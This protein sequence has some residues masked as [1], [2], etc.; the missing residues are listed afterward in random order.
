MPPKSSYTE[1]SVKRHWIQNT[2]KSGFRC[3]YCG[4]FRQVWNTTR[5][6]QHSDACSLLH[7]SQKS[8]A[9]IAVAANSSQQ[10]GL[11][12]PFIVVNGL[13]TFPKA[14]REYIVNRMARAVF[15]DNLPFNIFDPGHEIREAFLACHP[16]M[17]FPSSRS[18]SDSRLIEQYNATRNTVMKLF[19]QEEMIGFC[20]DE[21]NN[22]KRERIANICV[23]SRSHGA[24]Y[25][26]SINIKTASIDAPFLTKWL[27]TEMRAFIEELGG[28]SLK[29]IS[30]FSSDTY[31]TMLAVGRIL[32]TEPDFSHLIIVPCESYSLQLLIKD[33]IELPYWNDVFEQAGSIVRAFLRS[34]K[35][36]GILRDLMMKQYNEHRS[37]CLSIIT[38]W[39]TQYRLIKSLA[40]CKAVLREYFEFEMDPD[41]VPKSIIDCAKI[42]GDGMFWHSI[43]DCV[44][45]FSTIDEELKK[46]ESDIASICHTIGH[47]NSIWRTIR[48][49]R[50]RAPAVFHDKNGVDVFDTL[51]KQ[52]TDR[53][54]CDEHYLAWHLNP[55]VEDYCVPFKDILD[56]RKACH[57]VLKRHLGDR[58]PEGM[59]EVQEFVSRRGRIQLEEWLWDYKHDVVEFWEQA[60]LA[61]PVVG[62]LAL[63]LMRTMASSVPSERAFSIQNII[64]STVRN[65]LIA[66]KVDMLQ[67][68]YINERVLKNKR[69][70]HA[71]QEELVELEDLLLRTLDFDT[72]S[73]ILKQNE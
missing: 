36:L 4:R 54:L 5:L 26:K 38:R 6:G 49:F 61:F 7:P 40:K 23:T 52:R 41:D 39:G 30:L 73:S 45:V 35:Q 2:D 42:I 10:H 37:F 16:D 43:Q 46:S 70:K 71:K 18:L 47:W 34:H 13:V 53:Q 63:R 21:S 64:H 69:K 12:T 20:A 3:K 11:S 62:Q 51:W 72:I 44:P 50:D 32:K 66:E 60:Q 27:A 15:L 22:I 65:R 25:L 55:L 1:A 28:K 31:N 19:Q 33:L 56:V 68:I 58:A 48:T 24:F 17:Q 29:N 67:F 8:L 59:K 57:N 9:T 14:R